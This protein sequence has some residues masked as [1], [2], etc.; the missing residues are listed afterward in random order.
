MPQTLECAFNSVIY[1]VI[2]DEKLTKTPATVEALR[3]KKCNYDIWAQ[4]AHSKTHSKRSRDIKLQQLQTHILR[5]VRVISKASDS[6]IK[7]KNTKSLNNINF[8]ESL[9][10]IEHDCT[11]SIAMFSHVNS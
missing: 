3:I 2:S 4:M 10:S 5:A 8:K 1:I 7:L 6:L 11:D 9:S